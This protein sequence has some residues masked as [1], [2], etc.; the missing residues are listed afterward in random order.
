M[1]LLVAR[2]GLTLN[3]GQMADLVLVWRQLTGL[4]AALP[5]PDV[6]ADDQAFAF[7]LRPPPALPVARAPAPR[8]AAARARPT[9]KPAAKS[10]RKR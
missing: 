2:T 3:P 9:A 6:P 10:A 1:D 4:I 7:R 5:R 8:K